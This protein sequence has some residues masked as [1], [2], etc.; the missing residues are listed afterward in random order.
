MCLHLIVQNVPDQLLVALQA[1]YLRS[2]GLNKVILVQVQLW[3]TVHDVSNNSSQC[4]PLLSPCCMLVGLV[5][6]VQDLD[7]RKKKNSLFVSMN[8]MGFGK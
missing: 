4:K 2:V 5:V 1:A 8:L 3:P 7:K 6:T